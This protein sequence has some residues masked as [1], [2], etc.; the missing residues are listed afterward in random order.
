MK[1][2]HSTNIEFLEIKEKYNLSIS[3][4]AKLLKVHI[5]TIKAYTRSPEGVGHNKCP[6]SRVIQLKQTIQ[7]KRNNQRFSGID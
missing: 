3:E 5:N 1:Q 2:T 6:E 7:L 4:L